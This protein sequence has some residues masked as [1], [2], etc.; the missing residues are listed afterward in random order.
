MSETG[1]A[2]GRAADPGTPNGGAGA[3][4]PGA[5]FG[6]V[7]HW[8]AVYAAALCGV[9]SGLNVGKVPV[10]LPMLRAEFGLTL[11][12]AGWVASTLTTLAV[13]FA[14]GVGL[15][16]ARVGALPLV[17]A[18]LL[19]GAVSS[20]AAL[21][22]DGFAGL[23]ATR[24]LEGA[25]FLF[26]AVA[27]PT[28]ITLAT[29]PQDRRFAM[30]VWSGYM[31]LGAGLA[32]AIAPLLLSSSGWRALW[33]VVAALLLLAAAVCWQQ[34]AAYA[35][36]AGTAPARA[37]VKAALAPLRGPMPWLFA[38]AFMVWAQQHFAL[39]IWLP[40][41]LTE[42]RGL[43]SGWVAALTCLM[44]LANVPGNLIGGALLQRGVSRGRLIAIAHSCTGLCGWWMFSDTL[45]DGLRYALCVALSFIGG[46]IPVAVMS[47]SNVWAKTP[48]QIGVIQ[49]LIMQGSQ[50]GQ[51]VGTPLIAAVVAASGQWSSARW[52]TS[53]AA[54]I[55][56]AVALALITLERHTAAQPQ[57]RWPA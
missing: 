49:G 38:L 25:G 3:T 24:I 34:R 27:G 19:L 9:A 54:L 8:P 41:F 39:I 40:T 15:L 55:G 12:Q 22:A 20:L 51:F 7:T 45:P 32:I 56:V 42:Q 47:S 37:P 11:V 28:L 48:A 33:L 35:P 2:I 44:L 18:G 50:F 13:L 46:L 52:V 16:A 29:A 6:A 57:A 31:P 26:V 10:S 23:L 17:L 14:L 30:G 53:A 1:A 43:S 36:A 4:A 5:A 21:G